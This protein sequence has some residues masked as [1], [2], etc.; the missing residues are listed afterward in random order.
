MLGNKE[1]RSCAG[2][3]PSR[4][5]C[6]E[7]APSGRPGG[8]LCG[9]VDWK[10]RPYRTS[11]LFAAANTA[12]WLVAFSSLRTYTLIALL[13]ALMVVMA[14]IRD[15]VRHTCKAH[16]WSSMSASW[17]MVDSGQDSGSS[18]GLHLGSSLR[19]FL[20]E[21]SAFKQQNPGKFCLLV[22]SFCTFF[23]VLGRYIPGIVVSYLLVLSVFL[24]PLVSSKEVSLWLKPLLQKLDFGIG[25]FLRKMKK[26]H[27]RRLGQAIAEREA[28]ESDLSSMFPKLDSAAC[29]EM[30]LSD[31]SVSEVTWTDNSAFNLSEEHTP[32]TE[33]SEDL[34]REEV[35]TGGLPE[36]PSLDN[37]ESTNGDEDDD[38][39]LPQPIRS[40]CAPPQAEGTPTHKALDLVQHMASDVIAVAAVTAAIQERIKA[41]VGFTASL[42]QN[43]PDRSR[44][45][46]STR[47]L[48][49]VE[50]LDSEV[51]DFELLDQAELDQLEGELGLGPAKVQSAEDENKTHKGSGFFSKLLRRQ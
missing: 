44:L 14:T 26:N 20:Q 15:V 34:D 33:N 7:E 47:A 12:L 49:L 43:C 1:A 29:K 48:E 41:T 31:T 6:G 16:L 23:A 25:V 40:K 17:E 51:E 24:W 37:G 13:L 10:H 27:E 50:E 45:P 22:C 42:D 39:S 5:H 11:A 30:S 21:T 28:I 8:R 19:L 46:E 2:G 36:F 35:F 32:Q 9:L 4:I 18:A 3:S 38:F